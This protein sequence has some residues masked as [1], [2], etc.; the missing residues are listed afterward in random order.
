ME[1]WQMD[2]TASLF[3]ADGRECKVITGIDDHS[4][5]CVIATVMQRATA[6]AVCLA[7]TAATAAHR[8]PPHQAAQGLQLPLTPALRG[9]AGRE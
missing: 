7:F 8:Q 1:L 9:S 6:R 2:V 3:L 4:R 5:F